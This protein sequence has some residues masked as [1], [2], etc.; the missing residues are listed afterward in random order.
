[1][2]YSILIF[3]APET[4]ARFQGPDGPRYMSQWQPFI[5]ALTD[6]GIYVT[7]AGLQPPDTATTLRFN[8]DKRLVQDGPYADT[9]EQLGGFYMIDVPDLDAAL[10]WAARTPRLQGQVFEVRPNLVVPG[11]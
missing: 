4:T 5:K 1:M 2:K 7:G 8:G 10:E 3:D 9:K 6:A 11:N